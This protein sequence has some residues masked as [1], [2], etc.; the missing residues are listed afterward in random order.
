MFFLVPKVAVVLLAVFGVLAAWRGW[1]QRKG[2][3]RN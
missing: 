3:P 1:R 2:R